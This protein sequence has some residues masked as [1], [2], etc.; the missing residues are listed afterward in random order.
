MS[1]DILPFGPGGLAF[2]GF[3]L[4]SLIAVGWIGLKARKENTL[5]DF[6]L[7]GSGVGFFVLVLTLYATQYSGNTMLGFSGKAY[8]IGYSW[9]TSVHFM[10]AIVVVFLTYAPKLHRLAKRYD[11]ITPTDFLN[12]RFGSRAMNLLASLIMVAALSNYLLAQL[13]AMGRA[14]QGLTDLDPVKAFAWGVLLLAA[15]MLLY[16]TLGGFRAVAWTDVIQ[17]SVLMVG[18]GILLV[19]VFA[20]FGSPQE[21]A[22]RLLADENSRAKILPPDS[23]QIRQWLSF[24]G[25]LGIGAA[26]YPHAIQRIYAARSSIVLR[27]GLAAMA[28]MPLGT[29]LIALLVGVMGTAYIPGLE[30]AQADRI[31]TVMLREVQLGSVFGYWLVV[32]LFSAI[33]AAMMSTADS[34]LLS[35]SSMVTKDIYLPF[36]KPEA[37]EAQLTK[38]GK[39]FSWLIV[40]VLAGIAIKLDGLKTKLTLIELLNMKFDM[41]VQLGPAFLIGIHWKAMRAGPTFAGMFVGLVV[42]LSLYPLATLKNYGVH[43]GHFG[44]LANLVIAIGGSLALNRLRP[45]S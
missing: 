2:I 41:L 16:E 36:L 42:A 17:G 29:T 11:F 7:G 6:Y 8:R 33:L 38:L 4:C 14:F 20:K 34:A 45:K 26:L 30:G 10:M 21:A 43:P 31:L 25:I 3:Y 1:E 15:I 5:K 9:M 18:F 19:L 27:R 44:L 13:T 23:L 40:A 37:T 22:M 35:I 12:H 32:V 24:I 39:I 28:F